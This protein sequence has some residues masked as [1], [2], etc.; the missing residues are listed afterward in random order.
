MISFQNTFFLKNKNFSQTQWIYFI[1]LVVFWFVFFLFLTNVHSSEKCLELISDSEIKNTKT[2][3]TI[4]NL[5]QGSIVSFITTHKN[6]YILKFKNKFYYLHQSK[7][8]LTENIICQKLNVPFYIE[9][10]SKENYLIEGQFKTGD[11]ILPIST[12]FLSL[13]YYNGYYIVELNE[14]KIWISESSIL[15]DG[16]TIPPV[17]QKNLYDFKSRQY[18]V[19][20]S[21]GA[22][23]NYSHYDNII[24]NVINPNDVSDLPD[25]IISQIDHKQFYSIGGEV[26]FNFSPYWGT[27]FGLSYARHTLSYTELKNPPS[28]SIVAINE[29]KKNNQSLT[30]DSINASVGLNFKYPELLSKNFS[31]GLLYEREYYYQGKI[32]VERR[33]GEEFKSIPEFISTGPS[34]TDNFHLLF[35]YSIFDYTIRFLTYPTEFYQ[36]SIGYSI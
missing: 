18:L 9:D 26:N 3:Q 2:K 15:K 34:T 11:S 31:F 32:E 25:P 10:N 5:P 7:A 30:H 36:V 12:Q 24:T 13:A 22:N 1:S 14:E 35:Q 28:Q 19:L 6:F 27:I 23:Q 20:I 8:Q 16:A 29:L 4:F 33:I 17:I 21:Y